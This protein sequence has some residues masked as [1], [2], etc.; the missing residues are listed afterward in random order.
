M[1]NVALNV[2]LLKVIMSN[3]AS[4]M[5]ITRRLLPAL[6]LAACTGALAADA[7][8]SDSAKGKPM[9]MDEPMA[10]EMKRDDMTKG[11][12]K[13]AAEKKDREMREALEKEQRSAGAVKK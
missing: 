9:K 6:A 8:H 7:P 5:V 4:L 13:K 1:A 2:S 10:G 3:T 11:D 12:V